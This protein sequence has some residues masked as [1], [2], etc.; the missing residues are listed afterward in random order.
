VQIGGAGR[1]HS[2]SRRG[3]SESS[4]TAHVGLSP[5]RRRD[6][7]SGEW[8]LELR[9]GATSKRFRV[10]VTAKKL[11]VE[12]PTQVQAILTLLEAC[13]VRGLGCLDTLDGLQGTM[14]RS[15]VVSLT[16]PLQPQSPPPTG[17]PVFKPLTWH[18]EPKKGRCGVTK[19][20]LHH[21]AH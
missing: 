20:C 10:T 19:Q 21:H 14:A 1:R 11:R 12:P 18:H 7:S 4:A 2:W 6:L 15:R 5:S 13:P 8:V 17:S 3:L 16:P 9:T